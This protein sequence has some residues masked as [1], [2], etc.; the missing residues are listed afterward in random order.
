[1]SQV[2]FR[3]THFGAC[4]AFTHVTARMLAESLTGPFTP[5]ASTASLPPQLL[6]LLPAEAKVAGRDSHP[7]RNS[8]FHGALNGG[9]L[10]IKLPAT[11]I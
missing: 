6:Q 2:G 4:S 5:E 3:N 8:A 10:I 11:A 7:L 9:L 1:L